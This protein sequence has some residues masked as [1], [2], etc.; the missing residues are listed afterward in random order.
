MQIYRNF[1]EAY[2]DLVEAVYNEYDFT[3]A[4]RGQKIREILGASFVIQDP[5][6][7][8][9][10]I[11]ERKFSLQYVIA[12]ILWY[13]LGDDKTDWIGN[14]STI[15]KN[16]SDDG[17]TA[18][19]AYGSRIFKPHPKISRG[20]FTQWQYVK[21][22]LTRDPDSRRAVIHIRTP[23]DSIHATKDVPCTL[24]LQ[25]FIREKKLI[26]L[27]N[28]RSTD[29]IFGLGN[30]VPAFT[31]MQEMMAK[32]LGVE[33]G[34]YIHVSN[35]LHVYERHFEMCE[36]I[37]KGASNYSSVPMPMPEIPGEMPVTD[38]DAIQ[39]VA[40][41]YEDPKEIVK[42]L[43]FRLETLK[44]SLWRDWARILVI[45]RLQKLNADVEKNNVVDQIEFEGFRR[46]L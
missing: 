12:E 17:V 29:L 28:M 45:H 11:P 25:F 46:F 13:M 20:E 8:L 6:N 38:L 10:Q 33:L 32:E 1:T 5:R 9:L 2:Y 42:Y 23:E 24:S 31:F 22:E 41:M 39:A 16:I 26:L 4:P 15:W 18:N 14:Y 37:L 19:S 43:D 35:S 7:R 21:D 30:D 36:Q 27:V 44:E 40:R 3:C 34:P